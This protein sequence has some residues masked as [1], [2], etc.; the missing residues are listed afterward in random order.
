MSTIATRLTWA[1]FVDRELAIVERG[2]V[3]SRD[4]GF[5]LIG[6]RHF[7]EPKTAGAS[8]IPIRNQMHIVNG[9]MLLKELAEIILSC[10]ERNIANKD[11][12]AFF[13][14]RSLLFY[15]PACPGWI[16]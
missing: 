10:R 5:G 13:L 7:Y 16:Q 12:H 14:H 8:C 4:G 6:A 3:E 2:A 1:G 9:A 15:V 11:I